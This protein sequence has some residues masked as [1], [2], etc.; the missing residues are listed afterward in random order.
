MF[1]IEE[2]IGF[3]LAKVHQRGFAIFKEQLDNYELTPPQF[4]LLAF[5]WVKDGLSQAELTEKSQIDRTTMCGLIDRLEK[6]GLVKRLPHPID[7]RA[8]QIFLTERSKGLE[9]ELCNIAKD[10]TSRFTAPL[11]A[12]E[13]ETLRT[14]LQKMRK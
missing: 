4:S 8:Y 7:R 14:L 12:L 1:D 10:V 3:L 13:C 11:T 2:S 5:L 6:L 9:P